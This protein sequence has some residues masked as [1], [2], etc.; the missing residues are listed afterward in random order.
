MYLF[1]QDG[2]A[3]AFRAAHVVVG[4][5][6]IGLLWFF[7]FVQVP[8]FAELDAPARNHALDKLTWRAL[9]WFRWAAAATAVFGLFIVGS[10]TDKYFPEGDTWGFWSSSGGVTLLVGILFGLTMFANVWMIIWPNQ[11]IVIANARNVLAGG[12]AN[13]DAPAAARRGAMASRQ[14]TIFS[15]PLLVF[16]LGAQH[17][18][19]VTTTSDGESA[20]SGL[21]LEGDKALIYLLIGIAILA[22]LEVNALGKISGTGSGGLNVIYET[23]KNAM[24]TG[25][26]L[27]VLFYVLAEILLTP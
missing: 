18:Y 20:F 21:G 24:Y 23:H 22:V 5:M 9:W 3:E 14:N 8:A 17:I 26:G 6:W 16:M 11:Q 15:L 19:G 4:V 13:P 1:E 12:E 25:I 27:I 10:F 2:I 7:N